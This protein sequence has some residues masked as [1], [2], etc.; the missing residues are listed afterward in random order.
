MNR[1]IPH[2]SS[3]Q[4]IVSHDYWIADIAQCCDIPQCS[5]NRRALKIS[6][7]K[8]RGETQ[9]SSFG[10]G[11]NSNS[12]TEISSFKVREAELLHLQS[13][14]CNRN[15]SINQSFTFTPRNS[16]AMMELEKDILGILQWL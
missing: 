11:N 10:F 9:P 7:Y 15:D 14:T 2:L 16:K 4:I 1:T 13:G 12:A 3:E 6:E 8:G 5:V